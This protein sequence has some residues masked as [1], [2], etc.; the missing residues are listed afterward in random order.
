VYANTLLACKTPPDSLRLRYS[1]YCKSTMVPFPSQIAMH[2]LQESISY[3]PT[4]LNLGLKS[5]LDRKE[6]VPKLSAYSFLLPSSSMTMTHL[7]SHELPKDAL[8]GTRGCHTLPPHPAYAPTCE[9]QK[10]PASPK[11]MPSMMPSQRLPRLMSPLAMSL[12]AHVQIPWFEDL[13]SL[14]DDEDID[15]QLIAASQSMGAL[16][17]VWR[18]QHLNTYSKYL[19]FRAIPMNLLPWKCKN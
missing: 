9:S 4:L 13:Y 12:L 17:E 2:S 10:V 8:M 1:N 7:L 5:T 16:N 19:L 18:N 11:K 6:R 14:R 3:T 15:A